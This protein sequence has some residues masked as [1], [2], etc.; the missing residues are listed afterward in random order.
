VRQ[1]P[2]HLG[3]NI[4]V[5]VPFRSRATTGVHR[6]FSAFN[7][8]AAEKYARTGTIARD[9]SFRVAYFF[10]AFTLDA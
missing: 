7:R 5:G 1:L 10:A 8:S 2:H 3:A 4:A 9:V 6:H